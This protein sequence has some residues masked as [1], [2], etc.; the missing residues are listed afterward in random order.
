MPASSV[1]GHFCLHFLGFVHRFTGKNMPASQPSSIFAEKQSLQQRV[2]VSRMFEAGSAALPSGEGSNVIL[3]RNR[4]SASQSYDIS[5]R[6]ADQSWTERVDRKHHPDDYY[7]FQLTDRS[8]VKLELRGLRVDADLV[9]L[10][11]RGRVLRTSTNTGTVGERILQGLGAGTYYVRVHA[12]GSDTHY[13]FTFAATTNPAIRAQYSLD[14]FSG[15]NVVLHWNR[16]LLGTIQADRTAPPV[17]ARNLAILHTAIYD[18]VNSIVKMGRQYLTTVNTRPGASAVAAAAQA[19]YD[20]LVALYPTQRSR[21]DAEL[22]RSLSRIPNGQAENDGRAIGRAV[23][24]IVLSS[25]RNDGSGSVVAYT[26]LPGAEYWKPTAP[27]FGS[28]VLP[29]WPTVKPFAMTRGRQFRPAAPPDYNSTTYRNQLQETQRLGGLD[30]TT[31]T[32]DQTQIALFWADGSGTYTPPGHWNEIAQGVARSQNTTLF[33]EARLFAT[34]NASLADSGI[35]CWD[36]KYYYNQ[37][38]PI[39]AIRD[40]Y[41]ANWTPLL[42]TPSFPDYAS[43]H[44][45]FSGAASTVLSFF[46]GSRYRFSTSSLGTPGVQRSFQSFDAAARE[47]GRSRIYGGIHVE[48]ANQVGLQMGCDIGQYVLQQVMQS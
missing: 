3:P 15:D 14:G 12:T 26:P 36:T 48:S 33:Q 37:C 22:V 7:R 34:L 29:Q 8:V 43:G 25:R 32:A 41:D 1:F 39:T 5:L 4:S 6:E 17:A 11:G 31:R 45:T 19:G 16:T 47:A 35:A 46:F 38:R 10:D 20:T 2:D 13:R 27:G 24:Q 18:A 23:A 40:L 9:L 42:T 21:F 28:A 30:S 44:S